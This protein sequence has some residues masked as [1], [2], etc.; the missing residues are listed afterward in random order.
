MTITQHSP[1]TAE[2]LL[3]NPLAMSSARIA[4]FNH[5]GRGYWVKRPERLG[6][7]RRL[8]KGDAI[9]NFHREVA[10]LKEFHQQGAAVV[11]IAAETADCII[12]PDMGPTLSALSGKLPSDEF[13]KVLTQAGIALAAL[14]AA[15]LSHGRPRLRDICWTGTDIC[16][17]DLEAGAQLNAPNWRQA[18]DVLLM[19]HSIFHDSAESAQHVPAVLQ[20]YADAGQ[21]EV[22]ALASKIARR[23]SPLRFIAAPF[24]AR[25]KRRDKR[26]SEA[27]ALVAVLTHFR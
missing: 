26:Q 23:L 2:G 10:L 8:Q 9:A 13:A 24:A 27:A 14:H 18:L 21:G 17:L 22:L 15:D 12:L 4:F 25:D 20:A 6:K 1:D 3:E 16:F 19:V 5:N 7:L 11:P